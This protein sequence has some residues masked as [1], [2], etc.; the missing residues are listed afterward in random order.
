MDLKMKSESPLEALEHV[1]FQL[2]LLKLTSMPVE[3]TG[4]SVM[5]EVEKQ[6]D[7]VRVMNELETTVLKMHKP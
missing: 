5:L 3:L 1:R 7:A 2:D 4:P 6:E